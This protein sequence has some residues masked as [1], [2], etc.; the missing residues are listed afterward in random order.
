MTSAIIGASHEWSFRTI[1]FGTIPDIVAD[2]A[3]C[4]VLMVRRYRPE[5]W[6]TRAADQ[7]KRL[8]EAAGITTSP[9]TPAAQT[10][11]SI[12]TDPS[13]NRAKCEERTTR[14]RKGLLHAHGRQALHWC[15][16]PI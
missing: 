6:M 13:S 9:D 3:P 8:K 14:E 7:V 1:V 10:L 5:R 12:E 4:S 16:L 11:R 2:C 15:R